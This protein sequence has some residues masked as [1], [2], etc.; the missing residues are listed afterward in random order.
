MLLIKI[1][2]C[3]ISFHVE[4]FV[5]SLNDIKLYAKDAFLIFSLGLR[6]DQVCDFVEAKS[7]SLELLQTSS[8]LSGGA[9]SCYN[10]I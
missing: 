1:C 10:R 3:T 9:T 6:C 2:E 8:R 5:V 4:E 7:F